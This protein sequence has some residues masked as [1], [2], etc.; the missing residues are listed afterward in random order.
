MSPAQWRSIQ[1]KWENLRMKTLKTR[2]A[3][4]PEKVKENDSENNLP[5]VAH[6]VV[7]WDTSPSKTTLKT[8]LKPGEDN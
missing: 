8:K 6:A 5:N 7:Y 4:T 2:K 1:N 3:K